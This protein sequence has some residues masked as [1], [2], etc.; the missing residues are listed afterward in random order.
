MR[1]L[2]SGAS[3]MVGSELQENLL[4]D[5]HEPYRLIRGRE[6]G[7]GEI[8]WDPGQGLLDAKQVAGFDAVVH[9]AGEN[10]AG[11]RWTTARK[12]RIRASRINGTSLLCS[13]LA[14]SSAAPPV[15][16]SASGVGAYPSCRDGKVVDEGSPLGEGFLAD[17]ARDWEGATEALAKSSTR[18]IKLRI[19]M[20]LS[21]AGGALG[22]MLLP[23]RLGLGGR[24]GDGRQVISW[25]SIR[26][27]VGCIRFLLEDDQV[28]G[29]VNAVSPNPVT[30]SEFT[31]TLGKVLRRPTF[32]AMPA[33]MVSLLFGQMGRELLLTGQRVRPARLEEA[34]YQFLQPELETALRELLT[35]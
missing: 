13:R 4:G 10:I 23:F 24:F 17:T 33:F 26:D 6:P 15:F 19:G 5:G 9:L 16:I 3:G 1:I 12:A 27:L 18:L 34:G 20:V 14:E 2:I 29:I 7:P 28:S 21:P 32:M 30:N 8:S 22:K 11:G 25:I 35:P 31:K